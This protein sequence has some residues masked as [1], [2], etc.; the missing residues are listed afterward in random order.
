MPIR[1][2]ASTAFFEGA[3]A[4]EEALELIE[5]L[6]ERKRPKVNLKACE[7][8]HTAILQVL[9]ALRPPLSERP[10]DPFLAAWVA[11]LLRVGNDQ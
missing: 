10:D 5:W 8:L 6:R 1:Y 9:L 3:C 4:P 2:E 11:P 7:H